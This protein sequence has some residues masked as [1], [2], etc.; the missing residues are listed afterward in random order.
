MRFS[1]KV[2]SSHYVSQLAHKVARAVSSKKARTLAGAHQGL[3]PW[4]IIQQV[5]SL[6]TIVAEAAV[7]EVTTQQAALAPT[8]LSDEI[9]S[10]LESKTTFLHA[11]VPNPRSEFQ[12]LDKEL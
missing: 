12:Q 7:L 6:A 1:F 2:K 8:I 3:S 5:G 9:P 4:T 10:Q 11:Q